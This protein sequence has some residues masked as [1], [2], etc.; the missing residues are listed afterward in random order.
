MVDE[1]LHGFTWYEIV[2]FLS[3]FILY[4]SLMLPLSYLISSTYFLSFSEYIYILQWKER[5]HILAPNMKLF[6][7]KCMWPHLPLPSPQEEMNSPLKSSL[8][9]PI[10]YHSSPAENQYTYRYSPSS[11]QLFLFFPHPLCVED[12]DTHCIS[13]GLHAV[14]GGKDSDPTPTSISMINWDHFPFP[15]KRFMEFPS[16]RSG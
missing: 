10:G 6:R 3:G 4:L 13:T 2:S 16:W 8:P 14:G 9:T 1:M 15:L 11:S 7:G 12:Q 5:F